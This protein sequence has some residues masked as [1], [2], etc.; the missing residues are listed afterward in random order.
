LAV[1]AVEILGASAKAGVLAASTRADG[2][3]H[4]LWTHSHCEQMVCD[5]LAGRGFHPFLPKIDV[6]SV[7]AGHRRIISLQDYPAC[8]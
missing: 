3:W 4:V 1:A 6:W 7:R 2:P 5:Q 8:S